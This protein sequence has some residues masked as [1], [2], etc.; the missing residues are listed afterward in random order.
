MRQYLTHF[1][2]RNTPSNN[3]IDTLFKEDWVFPEIA[4]HF[5]KESLLVL[6]CDVRWNNTSRKIIGYVGKTIGLFQHVIKLVSTHLG[7]YHQFEN[8]VFAL[9]LKFLVLI[10][11]W[12]PYFRNPSYLE[13]PHQILAIGE[14]TE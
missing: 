6:K 7:T 5:C 4:F 8:D 2:F 11:D 14:P 12:L 10:D 9:F 13:S 1:N 3:M